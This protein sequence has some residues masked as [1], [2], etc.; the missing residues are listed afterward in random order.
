MKIG[1]CQKVVKSVLRRRE[2]SSARSAEAD[3]FRLTVGAVAIAILALT[4]CGSLAQSEAARP[5]GKAQGSVVQLVQAHKVLATVAGIEPVKRKFTV[6]TPDGLQQVVKAGPGVT[7]FHH[8]AIGKQVKPVLTEAIVVFMGTNAPVSG[9]PGLQELKAAAAKD[10]KL[11]AE[12]VESKGLVTAVDPVLRKVTLQMP[13]GSA[14]QLA[15]GTEVDLAQRKA[16]EQV[17]VCVA[18]PVAILVDT[19][20]D[21]PNAPDSVV[22]SP[23]DSFNNQ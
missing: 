23:K 12:T 15:V 18:E 9:G 14:R 20:C 22:R 8:L 10:D 1:P 11:W 5:V 7:N 6:V 19:S 3:A 4:P 13:A 16:G 21:C 17:Y 2:T